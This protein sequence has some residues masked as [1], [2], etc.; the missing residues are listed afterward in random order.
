MSC[1]NSAKRSS[2][3]EQRLVVTERGFEPSTIRVRL[4]E[5]IT[6]VIT[7]ETERTCAHE[8]VIDDHGVEAPLPLGTPVRVTITPT[9]AGELRFGCAMDKMVG[10]TLIV[11]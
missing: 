9:V 10:G 7:R 1:C 11:E 6:L 2:P 8:I 4:G 3:D 5:P